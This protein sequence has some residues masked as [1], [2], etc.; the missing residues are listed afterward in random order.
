[1]ESI[2]KQ[3][4]LYDFYGELLTDHQRAVYEDAVFNDM[5]LSEIAQEQG[6]SRQGV[7]DLIK[8][9]DRLLDGYEEKLQLVSKFQKTRQ[10][11]AEIRKK[12]QQ[13]QETRD[14]ELIR[15]ID[16]LSVEIME[17]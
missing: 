1:M 14:E 2:V 10:M 5:S 12:L 9:C 13:F 3:S 4:L 11:V 6:I 15:Q 8:R 16:Q 17:L 7:H